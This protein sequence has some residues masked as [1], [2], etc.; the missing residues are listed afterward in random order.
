MLNHHPRHSLLA[1]HITQYYLALD[2]QAHL[3]QWYCVYQASQVVHAH[4]TILVL[5]SVTKLET[6][7]WMGHIRPIS[8]ACKCTRLDA[9]IVWPLWR[10]TIITS[11][12]TW[13]LTHVDGWNSCVCC[14]QSRAVSE[15]HLSSASVLDQWWMHTVRSMNILRPPTRLRSTYFRLRYCWNTLWEASNYHENIKCVLGGAYHVS[16]KWCS[17]ERMENV[18]DKIVGRLWAVNC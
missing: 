14:S 18:R 4:T 1:I 11:S 3:L 9:S 2:L 13:S 7:R 12:S 6:H 16:L 5:S 15:L 17:Q 8:K 10:S